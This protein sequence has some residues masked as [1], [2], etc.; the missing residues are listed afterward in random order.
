[1]YIECEIVVLTDINGYL[2]KSSY[3]V[4]NNTRI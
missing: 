2:S 4:F 1:M 3:E